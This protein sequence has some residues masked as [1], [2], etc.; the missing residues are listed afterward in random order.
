MTDEQHR[1]EVAGLEQMYKLPWPRPRTFADFIL[2]L[3]YWAGRLYERQVPLLPTILRVLVVTW[4]TIDV[5]VA[6]LYVFAVLFEH[7]A[8]TLFPFHKLLDKLGGK[9]RKENK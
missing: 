6:V 1:G 9:P 2:V 8:V 3:C 5:A 7:V 4:R